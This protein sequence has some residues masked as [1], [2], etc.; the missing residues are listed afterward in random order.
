MDPMQLA[1]ELIE[2]NLK[3]SYVEVTDLTGTRDHVG[4]LVVSDEFK[5][6]MLI[7]QHQMIMDILK[8]EFSRDLHAIQLKTMTKEKYETKKAA[9]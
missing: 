2:K 6:K 9:K 4:L 1:K 8:E 5:G 7:D 3:D